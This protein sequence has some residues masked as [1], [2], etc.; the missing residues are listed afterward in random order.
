MAELITVA[1]PYAQA[2]FTRAKET[3]KLQNWSATLQYAAEVSQVPAMQE[4]IK[5]VQ[6]EMNQL[7]D[8]FIEICGNQLDQEGCNMIRVLAE[9]RRLSL[10]PEIAAVYEIYRAEEE[11]TLEA[12]II[13]AFTVAD[14]QRDRIAAALT[15]KLGRTVNLT[16]KTDKSLLGGAVI[17]AGDMVIDGSVKR[18]LDKL[19]SAMSH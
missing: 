5:G 19:A 18:K 1:R 12:E 10:L 11:S 8:L 7:A 2:I 6:L 14:A 9:N 16:C 13:S 4:L 17:R 3:G 15:S